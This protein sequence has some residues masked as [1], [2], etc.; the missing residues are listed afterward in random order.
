MI[1]NLLRLNTGHLPNHPLLWRGRCRS[2]QVASATP[3][4]FHLDGELFERPGEEVREVE[5]SLMPGALRVM[6]HTGA[7]LATPATL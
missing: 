1:R 3:L 4:P 5:V 2:V 6:A 7:A